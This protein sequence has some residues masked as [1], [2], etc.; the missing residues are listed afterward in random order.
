MLHFALLGPME[1]RVDGELRTPTAPMAR[2][3]LAVLLAHGDRV[4]PTER[5]IE[6]LWDDQPPKCARKTV[7]TYIY[8]LRK[9]L[10]GRD[11][12]N[13]GADPVETHP[14]G[15]RLP[16]RDGALDLLDFQHLVREGKDALA[17]G[18]AREGAEALRRA[19][20]LWRGGVLEDVDTGPVLAAQTARVEDLRIQALERRIAA[21]LTLGHDRAV[22]E[23]TRDLTY[24]YPLHEE[25]CAQ[26]MT[27]ARRC[28]QR[29]EA[30]SAY[31]RLR[32]AM[33]Q[34]LGLEPS[35]RLQELQRAVL[36]GGNERPAAPARPADGPVPCQLPPAIA[37]F[38]GRGPEMRHIAMGLAPSA[39]PEGVE[40]AGVRIVTVTGGLGV[41]KTEVALQVAHRMRR[42]FP[43]G[44]L[45]ASLHLEDGTPKRPAEALRE[46]LAA[47]GHDR[48]DL[49]ERTDDLARLFRGWAAGRRMV[50]LLDDAADAEQ[51]GPLLPAGP[52]NAVIVTSRRRLEGLPG[53]V[54]SVGLGPLVEADGRRLL[55]R[56]IG[57]ERAAPEPGAVADVV[58]WCGG[59]PAAIRAVGSR[60]AAWPGRSLAEFAARL[61]DD[62]VRLEELS[63]PHLDVRRYLVESADR[64]P[65]SA[66][67]VLTE[68]SRAE[69]VDVTVAYLARRLHRSVPSIERSV[70]LLAAF[71][72]IRPAV[73]N[74]EHLL[75][76]PQ[77]FRLAFANSARGRHT[78]PG[79][80]GA[81]GRLGVRTLTARRLA[82]AAAS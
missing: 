78:D 47:A 11:G 59:L 38:V 74:G 64:L 5:F 43:D 6:E 73:W 48:A 40:P 82:C 14:H 37:G 18:R 69:R 58:A 19:L 4:V 56:V 72:V 7:Q 54:T 67:A 80:R 49:P 76:V 2:R 28:G 34:E 62:Q 36:A 12:D 55:A 39:F 8:Q 50:L 42:S 23:E 68:I 52:G 45:K 46:L 71:H 79:R 75:C 26:L 33:A 60:I 10:A 77:L 51:L 35:A 61:A 1:V 29:G 20:D 53:T 31:A 70:E 63:S 16:V 66:R 24:E 57:E 17:R 30:L 32:R 13:R 25:F 27:A 41:G 3:V 21:D 81:V 22:L 44:Q 65:H 9:A 15:Y